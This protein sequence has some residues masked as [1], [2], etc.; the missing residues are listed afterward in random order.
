M[1]HY[2]SLFP[3]YGLWCKQN[4][5]WSDQGGS[6]WKDIFR[7]IY[8]SVNGAFYKKLWKEFIELK[9]VYSN[10]YCWGYYDVS[11]N[12]YGVRCVTS[13]RFCLE[14]GWITVNLL[15]VVLLINLFRLCFEKFCCIGTFYTLGSWRILSADIFRKM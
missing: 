7:D 3:R 2:K 8:V 11:I 5:H 6:I 12:K 1:V 10:Y 15:I 13:L 9:N 14:N 4:T